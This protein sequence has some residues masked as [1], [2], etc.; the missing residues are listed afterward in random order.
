MFAL[1]VAKPQ[2][3][4]TVNSTNGLAP[5]RSTFSER[6]LGYDLVDD[7]RLQPT[8]RDQ[9]MPWL[10]QQ[11]EVKP[12]AG[13]SNDEPEAVSENVIVRAR[14]H[15]TSWNFITTP[16]FPRDQANGPQALSS[17][18]PGAIQPKL[19]IGA[20][21]DPFEQEADRAADAAMK[22]DESALILSRGPTGLS[23]KCAACAAEDGDEE[24]HLQA[25]PSGRLQAGEPAPASVHSV[26]AQHG[27]A[28][29]PAARGFLE[30]SFGRSFA[31]VRIHDGGDAAISA[32]HIGARAYT[33]GRNIVFGAGEYR[34]ATPEGRWLLAHELTHVVQQGSAPSAPGARAP[35]FNPSPVVDS[36]AQRE[37]P[38][39]G[40]PAPTGQPV[41][42]ADAGTADGGASQA[43]ADG[44]AAQGDAQLGTDQGTQQRIC[45]PDITTSLTTM[46]GKVEPWFKG[47]TGF[48]QSRS[49]AALGPGGFLVGVNPGMAWDT[50]ELFLPNTG[51]LDAY[52]RRKSCGS[53]RDPGCDTDPHRLLCE[54]PATC[55]N[56]VV[57]DGKCMLAG[58]ANYALF[59]KLCRI[60]H[61]YN[62]SWNRWDMRAII[63]VWK[64]VDWD[65]STPP[66]E[67]ASAAY[68][69]T[70]PTVPAAAENRGTCTGRCGLT[71]GGVFDFI[72][73]TYKPR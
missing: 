26:V 55:G 50:R 54:T 9:A 56:S 57:V 43:A 63:G 42:T 14:S 31:D 15:R 11:Q 6:H 25:K 60:C 29:A 13:V 47:L 65:D 73:E 52:F 7:A 36:V 53:P 28:L 4:A 69:G 37:T 1:K 2:T 70:F 38:T 48:Q 45:G 16:V 58:T 39:A 5:G 20:V 46:L 61:D 23:R 22:M 21:N 51:W 24:G 72:W 18:L 64:T 17:S 19:I 33:V 59:G 71:H 49:C 27:R 35:R 44:G 40:E 62:G 41:A 12:G 30:S 32:A 8:A 10:L 3:K 67:V 66:K 34:P 68:D